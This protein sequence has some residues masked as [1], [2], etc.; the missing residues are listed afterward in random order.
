MTQTIFT[1]AMVFD[2]VDEIQYKYVVIDNGT[3]SR[4]V[5]A[6]EAF[7]VP[8][9]AILIDMTGYMLLPGFF[10]AH[11][12]TS[13]D[14]L[15]T[16]LR[17]GVTTELEMM[18]GFTKK[19]REAQLTGKKG[20]ADVF[21]AGMGLTAPKGHPDELIPDN[22][23]GIPEFVLKEM[24]AMSD[25]E[26]E[27]FI[28]AHEGQ[29]EHGT[30]AIDSPEKAVEFV[31]KQIADGADYIKIMIEEGT[32][33]AAPGLPILSDD[34]LRAGIEE[35]HRNG[36]LVLA[37]TLTAASAKKA[38]E[39]GV[40]GLAHLFIDRPDWTPELIQM[41][42]TRHVF[43]IPTL[44]LGGSI[45]GNITQNIAADPRVVS[46]LSDDWVKT[47]RASFDTAPDIKFQDSLDNVADL[48]HS[49]VPILAGT[50]VSN[51][52][53][54]LGGLAHGASV[55]HEL[56]LLVQAGLSNKDA[57]AAAT[58]IPAA[59]FGLS[60]RGTI[61]EGKNAD[62]FVVKGNPLHNIADTLNIVGVWKEG[63][64]QI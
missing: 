26:R 46:R 62:L 19:G 37:H 18:G 10:D 15:Q 41:I 21:S 57:L 31:Q 54:S 51:P 59:I 17:F 33:L 47:L 13:V 12:H 38:V 36:K 34:I 29:H 63:E 56:Q 9:D 53:P 58:S 30:V 42:Q 25:S 32:V 60:D 4:L 11:T 48:F 50:D 27:A 28:K 55:H 22:D 14:G 52:D 6:T 8:E 23:G 1:D 35:A 5:K 64:R 43:V 3:I 24:A 20:L 49:H 16:A 2:G 61:A 40:N 39:L 7:T 45:S 44:V